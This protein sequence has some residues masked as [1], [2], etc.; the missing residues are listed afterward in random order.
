MNE[1]INEHEHR[2]ATIANQLACEI[3]RLRLEAGLSQRVLATRIGYSR[4]YV[5]MAEWEDANLPS[6]EL[7][8]AIDAA[9]GANG[10]LA[11]LRARAKGDKQRPREQSVSGA[12]NSSI[13][14][15]I[16]RRGE[17]QDIQE[18]AISEHTFPEADTPI[19][20]NAPPK[21][22]SSLPL[23]G[24]EVPADVIDILGRIHKLS[25]SISPEIVRHLQIN[26]QGMIERYETLDHSVAIPTLTK[27]R[28]WIDFLLDECSNPQQRRQLYN[29]AGKTSGL[30]GYMTVGRG[31]F[32]LARAY[33]LEAFELGN[34][35]EN[36]E[37]R[38]WA[39]G[40]QS[41]CEYYSGRYSEALDYARDGLTHAQSGPQSVRLLINGAARAL[42][43]LGNIEGVHRAVQESYDL[44]SRHEVS[45]GLPSSI[46]LE[47][48]SPAQVAGNAATAYL[49]LAMKSKVEQ[50][51]HLA[52]PEMTKAASPWSSS[53]VLID[54]ACSH[55]LSE[56][57]DM[58]YAVSLILDA[59]DIPSE[60]SIVSLRQRAGEFVRC[61]TDRW[62]DLPQ[63]YEVRDALAD[64]TERL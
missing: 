47:C 12:R 39:R 11:E 16:G 35:A 59:L 29:I 36:S 24:E 55:A 23:R 61:A 26:T 48:Y 46:T 7:I 62:G 10:S 28:S 43:K 45:A 38:A 34:L 2:S 53:L 20:G 21:Q 51:A 50:Y 3:K 6:Y 25:R 32:P 33:C 5:S 52:L 14:P 57:G 30:L 31:N 13:V 9:L 60:K 64:L 41:F 17:Q 42:G 22:V 56:K 1:P 18:P 27:Q 19:T 58:D 54:L 44:I 15:S 40:L 4:Q 37:T 63:L 8:S 49:S